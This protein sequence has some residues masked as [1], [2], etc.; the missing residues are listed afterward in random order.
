[1]RIAFTVTLDVERAQKTPPTPK[2]ERPPQ[3]DGKGAFLLERSHQDEPDEMRSGIAEH[4]YRIGF[5]PNEER[6]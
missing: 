3:I 2:P 6:A 1:M 4:W 5:R